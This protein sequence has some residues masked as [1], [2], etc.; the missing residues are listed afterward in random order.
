MQ[1]YEC[2]TFKMNSVDSLIF[3]FISHSL[4]C[5][6]SWYNYHPLPWIPSSSSSLDCLQAHTHIYIHFRPS[7]W[8]II[9][10]S[11]SC[12]DMAPS[13][14][15]SFQFTA[16]CIH[17]GKHISLVMACGRVKLSLHS[18]CIDSHEK[19]GRPFAYRCVC[20]YVMACMDVY[21]WVHPFGLMPH[22]FHHYHL[23]ITH[24]RTLCLN[25]IQT[26]ID[27]NNFFLQM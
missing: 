4:D 2:P 12:S 7:S 23:D 21:N 18:N 20:M 19:N 6:P 25:T 14:F 16:N 10:M 3:P 22:H 15:V 8:M 17:V 27:C 26:T 9:S 1:N 5:Y 13:I 11:E 24:C